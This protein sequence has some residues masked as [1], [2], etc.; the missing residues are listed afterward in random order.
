[1][2]CMLVRRKN[3][4]VAQIC[5]FVLRRLKTTFYYEVEMP[6]NATYSASHKNSPTIGKIVWHVKNSLYSAR[7]RNNN[8]LR[9]LSFL[10]QASIFGLGMQRSSN[11]K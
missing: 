4:I 8:Q 11:Q 10:L 6:A 2:A 9:R 7:Q 1:M 5:L 3:Y